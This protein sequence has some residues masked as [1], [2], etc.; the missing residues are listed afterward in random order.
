[1][2][3]DLG[4]AFSEKFEY[5]SLV[6]DSTQELSIHTQEAYFKCTELLKAILNQLHELF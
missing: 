5:V 4:S 2:L 1:M 3:L 6:M